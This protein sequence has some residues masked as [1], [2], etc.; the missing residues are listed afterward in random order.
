MKFNI[1]DVLWLT[2][3]IAMAIALWLEDNRHF[4]ATRKAKNLEAEVEYWKAT[5][6][7]LGSPLYH[8]PR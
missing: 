6:L 1:R 7:E 5:A 2:L 4:A 8:S 3:V